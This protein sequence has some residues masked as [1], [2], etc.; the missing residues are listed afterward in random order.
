MSEFV[1]KG[2]AKE[3]DAIFREQLDLILTDDEIRQYLIDASTKIE[4]AW[5]LEELED[6]NKDKILEM[7]INYLTSS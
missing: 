6:I 4:D 7:N 1:G 2:V 5:N 3:N